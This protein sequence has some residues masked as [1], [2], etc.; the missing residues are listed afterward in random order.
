MFCISYNP[1]LEVGLSLHVCCRD[2]LVDGGQVGGATCNGRHQFLL[3]TSVEVKR[4][5]VTCSQ[6]MDGGR[7]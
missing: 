1:C 3:Q 5:S 2:L 6:V 4:Y 7:T